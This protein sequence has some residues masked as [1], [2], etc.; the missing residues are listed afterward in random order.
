MQE[1]T[2]GPTEVYFREA[3]HRAKWRLKRRPERKN[4]P[5]SLRSHPL[6]GFL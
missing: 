4:H 2:S 3:I 6:H 5:N 1:G